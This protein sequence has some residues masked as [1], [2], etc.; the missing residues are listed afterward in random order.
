[1]GVARPGTAGRSLGRVRVLVVRHGCAG[2]KRLWEGPDEVR[3]VD[4]AGALQAEALVAAL[5]ARPVHRIVSSPTL[6]CVQTME[7]LAR[8]RGLP[9]ELEPALGKDGSGDGLLALVTDPEA[10]GAV[11]CTHRELMEKALATLRAARVPIEADE[12]DHDAVLLA[13]GSGWDLTVEEG[14]VT[15]LRHLHPDHR[16]D[17]SAHAPWHT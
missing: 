13:K 1:M 2:D 16:L 3:P 6:R 7:P 8:D 17:C 5:D 14:G 11:L 12:P 4:A 9:V 10:A 15:A